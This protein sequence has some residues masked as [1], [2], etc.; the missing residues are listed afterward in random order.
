MIKGPDTS[1]SALG[2]NAAEVRNL[3]KTVLRKTI[4]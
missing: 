1:R 2:L 3:P 4:N